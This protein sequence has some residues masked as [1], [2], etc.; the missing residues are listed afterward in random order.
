[1]LVLRMKTMEQLQIQQTPITKHDSA[2][3]KRDLGQTLY[4]LRKA[5]KV[6]Q[7]QLAQVLS[8][9]QA[10]VC[11]VENGTQNLTPAELFAVSKYFD[12]PIDSILANEVDYWKV[13]ERFGRQVPL[14]RRF[15]EHPY[16]KVREVLPVL[17]FL[18]EN[19][20][21]EECERV[22]STLG[23]DSAY[24]VNPDQTIGVYCFLDLVCLLLS[25]RILTR[26]NLRK[27]IDQ[28]RRKEVQG[29][30]HPL[31]Q[32]Q[33]SVFGSIQTLIL[34]SHHYDANF[35]YTL[36]SVTPTK[37]EVSIKPAEHMK[38]IDYRNVTLDDFLCAYRKQYISQF[39][40]YINKKPVIITET[41][42][43][44]RG[45]P[46]CFYKIKTN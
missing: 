29:F 40:T 21:E 25:E 13:A 9:H 31:Y 44:F 38:R 23:L 18:Y 2:K 3:V 12:V 43:H 36:E 42:C 27:V 45:A 10:A 5:A 28:T 14:P 7:V 33:E 41:E 19:L 17:Y 22:L 8:L 39:P 1:M 24:L 30:L 26:Q 34:N 20:S 35:K 11:R 6:S 46:Q 37:L 16:S 15:A 32:T 4:R